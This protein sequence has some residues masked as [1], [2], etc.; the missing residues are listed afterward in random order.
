MPSCGFRAGLAAA[1]MQWRQEIQAEFGIAQI[2]VGC[3]STAV[4]MLGR[5]Q[6]HLR[7]FD[8]R[9][10]ADQHTTG[11]EESVVRQSLHDAEVSAQHGRVA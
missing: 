8:C 9:M 6:A 3:T 10:R 4:G 7:R 1:A 5:Q 2:E 11:P